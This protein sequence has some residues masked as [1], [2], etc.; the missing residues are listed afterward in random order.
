MKRT[1]LCLTLSSLSALGCSKSDDKAAKPDPATESAT[2]PAEAAAVGESKDAAYS[3]E[4][5]AAALTAMQQCTSQYGCDALDTLV[6][7]GDKVSNDLFSL[8]VDAAKTKEIRQVALAGLEKIKDPAMG[9][10]LFE[11]AKKEEDFMV[12][13]GL[14]KAAGAGG[15][16]E[17]FAAMVGHYASDD[18]EE[19]RTEMRSGLRNFGGEML[20][21]WA[22]ENY[23]EDE[24][25]QIRFADLIGDSGEAADKDKTIELMTKTTHSMAK[26]RL[27]SFAVKLGGTEQISVLIEGLKSSDQYDRSDAASFL[28][29]IAESIPAAQKQEVIDLAT[30][31]KAKDAGGL[32]AM[33]YDKLLKKLGAE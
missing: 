26:H 18:S 2:N 29:D 23:P 27:A 12:R 8:A 30:A 17:T 10:G 9:M 15:N 13:A 5:A 14:F 21:S 6:G 7:F 19:H 22:A 33:G 11:A 31:A 20:F 28:V 3:P 1:L 4:A 32:T 25:K 24:D 16:A